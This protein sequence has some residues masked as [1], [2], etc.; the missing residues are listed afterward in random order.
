MTPGAR[1]AII[2]F[3]LP[4]LDDAE[5]DSGVMALTDL[6]MLAIAGGKERSLADLTRCCP[7]QGCGV[8]P[9]GRWTLRRA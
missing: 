5:G 6:S 7:T 1:V 8:S 3:L 9:C 4:D 2:E